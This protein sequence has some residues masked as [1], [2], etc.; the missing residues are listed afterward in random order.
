MMA[1]HSRRDAQPLTLWRRAFSSDDSLWPRRPAGQHTRHGGSEFARVWRHGQAARL[2]D[3]GLLRSAVA[4]RRDDRTGMAHAASL[5]CSEAGD[6]ANHRLIHVLSVSGR[7]L[8]RL[9][10]AD[11]AGDKAL[12]G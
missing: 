12:L 3:F 9:S 10:D 8:V 11:S 7:G 5:G 4:Y 6:E 1:G 2:H